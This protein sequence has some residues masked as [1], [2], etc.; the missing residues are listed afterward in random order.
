MENEII[1]SSNDDLIEKEKENDI[2]IGNTFEY[3]Q[4]SSK[5]NKKQQINNNDIYITSNL[6]PN[7]FNEQETNEQTYSFKP[8]KQE[9]PNFLTKEEKITVSDFILIN[10]ENNNTR[11][12][13]KEQT[14]FTEILKTKIELNE[15]IEEM[16][17]KYL[18]E[19]DEKKR[20]K[21]IKNEMEKRCKK[22]R[23]SI[24][25]NRKKLLEN[26]KRIKS[27]KK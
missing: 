22:L 12:I 8:I 1:K 9:T 13:N 25:I 27:E 14:V 20:N 19:I 17:Q 10:N 3:N 15:N 18:E 4:L 5:K 24:E 11:K 2:N 21:N 6:L 16:Q 26:K 23:E 7:S